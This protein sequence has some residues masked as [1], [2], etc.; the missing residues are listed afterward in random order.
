MMGRSAVLSILVWGSLLAWAAPSPCDSPAAR[1][2][3]AAGGE[4][5]GCRGPAAAL[6]RA[7]ERCEAGAGPAERRG[8]PRHP[9]IAAGPAGAAAAGA[10]ARARQAVPAA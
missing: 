10:V 2:L 4:S 3:A 9:D 8:D 5:R 1:D 6:G 7:G